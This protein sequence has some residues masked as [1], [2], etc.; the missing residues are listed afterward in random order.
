MKVVFLD[1]DGTVVKEPADERID[2]ID[3]I[4]VLPD[5]IDALAL[6]K[7]NGFS[8]VFVTNQAGIDEGRI[9]VKAFWKI[10]A[11]IE[12]RLA[13]SGIT[14]TATYMNPER[15]GN[16][17]SLWRKPGPNMLLQAAQDLNLDLSTV[18]MV[19]DSESDITA[20]SRAKCKGGIYISTSRT[21]AVPPPE[22]AVY[23]ASSLLDAAEYII[24][25]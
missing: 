13:P 22:H 1:R 15:G 24:N 21:A 7:D 9:D 11:E 17:T 18:Y 20:A 5:A 12:K 10:H 19:G 4:E 16:N 25:N 6:L 14:I 8:V 2:S 23:I 3:K